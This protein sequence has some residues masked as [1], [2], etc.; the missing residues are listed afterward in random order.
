MSL[1]LCAAMLAGSAAQAQTP[2]VK[3]PVALYAKGKAAVEKGDFQGALAALEPS[4]AALPSPNTLLLVAHAKR[5]LGRKVDAAREYERVAADA[6]A[7]IKAGEARYQATLQE[8][9]KWIETLATEL[10]QV[11][12]RIAHA[13]DSAT[14]SINGEKVKALRDGEHLTVSTFW[15]LPGHVEIKVEGEGKT[16]DASADVTAGGKADL[17]IDLAPPPVA[18]VPKAPTPEPDTGSKKI[19]MGFWIAGGAG[20]AGLAV[21]G[22]FGAMAKS[23]YDELQTCSPRCAESERSTA[24]SGKTKQTVA[25]IG[26][27][28]GGVGLATA[29]GILLFAPKK[30]SN[31]PTVGM[32]LGPG[33]VT[34]QGRF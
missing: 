27:V 7:K 11:N 23:D 14:V 13:P 29:A 31:Q 16:K 10:G 30:P 34:V 26:L 15:V 17:N 21:F 24:D 5:G 3:D 20:V 19:P 1:G 33:A 25:N 9:K 28:V 22:I 8:A 18:P 6:D 32:S 12:L 2:P 4:Y